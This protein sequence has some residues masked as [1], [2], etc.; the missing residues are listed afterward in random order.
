MIDLISC[1]SAGSKVVLNLVKRH[2]E[3]LITIIK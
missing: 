3:I 1:D 2:F